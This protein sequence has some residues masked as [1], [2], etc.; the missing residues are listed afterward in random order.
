MTRSIRTQQAHIFNV[1]HMRHVSEIHLEPFM[2]EVAPNEI[3][4][5]G[6]GLRHRRPFS[7]P[8]PA[9]F[10]HY[11]EYFG[12]AKCPNLY[13]IC[14]SRMHVTFS[15]LEKLSMTVRRINLKDCRVSTY[16]GELLG[17]APWLVIDRACNLLY[18][19]QEMASSFHWRRDHG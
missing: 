1:G 11:T 7:F 17:C 4:S 13:E 12:E 15:D 10:L 19:S 5:L 14:I 16:S 2:W 6:I 18:P 9:D 3:E 8:D